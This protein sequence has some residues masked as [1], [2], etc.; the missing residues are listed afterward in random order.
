MQRV[1]QRKLEKEAIKIGVKATS[2]LCEGLVEVLPFPGGPCAALLGQVALLVSTAMAN[3]DNLKALQEMAAE[4]M[5]VIIEKHVSKVDQAANQGGSR[6]AKAGSRM[7]YQLMARFRDLL[8]GILAYTKDYNNK[9]FIVKLLMTGHAREQYQEMVDNLAK[10]LA[11]AHFSVSVDTHSLVTNVQSMTA[12][13][14]GMVEDIRRRTQYTDRSSEVKHLVYELGGYDAARAGLM[15]LEAAQEEG[16]HSL[17][18]H[19]DMRT[20]W[21]M[22]FKGLP[23]VDWEVWWE[24]FPSQL[25]VVV[26]DKAVVEQVAARL[27]TDA[28]LRRFQEFVEK[29]DGET[30]SVKEVNDATAVFQALMELLLAPHHRLFYAPNSAKAE[31]GWY[32]LVVKCMIKITNN[33]PATVDSINIQGASIYNHTP[34]TGA[35]A[36][37]RPPSGAAI[38][39]RHTSSS[40][41]NLDAA[42]PR[43][44]TDGGP[45][46]QPPQQQQQQ[47]PAQ[48]AQGSMVLAPSADVYCQRAAN[49]PAA[50]SL[51][52]VIFK[53]I[54]ENSADR[55]QALERMQ[56]LREL[57]GQ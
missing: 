30:I 18:K 34:D 25:M 45:A 15:A 33:L 32:D 43:A 4:L 7:Y 29:R 55:H 16:V 42:G 20:F 39:S 28:D 51:L 6:A 8:D 40:S 48:V 47:Q 36:S 23:K 52:S 54:A 22:C 38:S 19:A 44:S 50:R 24:A 27:S 37:P 14:K 31:Q 26:Q 21:R 5:D 57:E 13:M 9:N 53:R 46:A 49:D 11:N 12:E 1:R 35:S 10:L 17:V 3:H 2:S 41:L 56:R